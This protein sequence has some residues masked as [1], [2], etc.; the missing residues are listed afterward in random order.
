[1][2]TMIKV[3]KTSFKILKIVKMN[4]ILCSLCKIASIFSQELARLTLNWLS[5]TGIYFAR[6]FRR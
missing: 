6:Y 1:M 5:V 2:S 3:S 4:I